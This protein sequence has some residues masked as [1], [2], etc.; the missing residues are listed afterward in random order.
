MHR[1][2][3]IVLALAAVP[4]L[5]TQAQA[6]YAPWCAY[7]VRGGTNCGFHS[8]EQ[9]MAHLSGIGGTCTRNRFAP[10]PGNRRRQY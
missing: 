5:S 9:C 1:K 2:A 8:W 3:L 10:P 7:D 4:L 6:Q